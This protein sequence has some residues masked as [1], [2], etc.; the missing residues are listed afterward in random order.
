M[1]S[2]RA[3]VAVV[4]AA[5]STV[6]V[7]GACASSPGASSDGTAVETRQDGAAP[8]VQTTISSS[9]TRT[10]E[11]T[12]VS[13]S[14]TTASQE[15][16]ATTQSANSEPVGL[17]DVIGPLT[18]NTP[19][20]GTPAKR[21]GPVEDLEDYGMSKI[22]IRFDKAGQ[23]GYLQY[24]VKGKISAGWTIY[25]NDGHIPTGGNCPVS[26]RFRDADGT[27]MAPKEPSKFDVD[28]CSH[29]I[30]TSLGDPGSYSI[31]LT[32]SI[33]GYSEVTFEQ[34]ILVV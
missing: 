4:V 32:V 1:I 9:S 31:L 11:S 15:D 25:Y 14:E 8:T 6:G 3:K 26:M 2:L 17:G 18:E 19:G 12:D 13:A 30:S 10:E 33:P 5:V 7:L 21:G 28:D 20:P 22:E 24:P 23:N 34:P 29:T 27:V 16:A